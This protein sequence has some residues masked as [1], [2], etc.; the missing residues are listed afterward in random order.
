[1]P[2]YDMELSEYSAKISMKLATKITN[3]KSG[4]G[5]KTKKVNKYLLRKAYKNDLPNE[6]IYRDKAVAI[7]NHIYLNTVMKSY[8]S[9]LFIDPKMKTTEV[10]EKLN[11]SKLIDLALS[12]NGKWTIN[13]YTTVVEIHNLLFLEIIAR[14]YNI[15]N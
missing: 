3:G 12:N 1:M 4:Y 2:F 13:D 10:Y 7:T 14:K 11:L 5:N 15:E 9:D 8:I 6:I